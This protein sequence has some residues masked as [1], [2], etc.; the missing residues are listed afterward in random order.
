M[1]YYATGKGNVYLNVQNYNN[2]VRHDIEGILEDLGY[3][4]D[5]SYEDGTVDIDICEYSKFHND[6][7]YEPL[8]DLA[9]KYEVQEGSEIEFEGEDGCRWCYRYTNGEWKELIACVCYPD[10][11]PDYDELVGM[12]VK[13]MEI[14]NESAGNDVVK[15]RL[16]A[17]GC[18]ASMRRSLGI[19]HLTGEDEIEQAS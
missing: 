16:E 7:T 14:L 5:I 18:N 8:N 2:D 1:G 4:H 11:K 19:C 15:E 17:L 3:D 6:D 10:G 12:F 9:Q 13:E